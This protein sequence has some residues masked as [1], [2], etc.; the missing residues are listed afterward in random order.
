MDR[1][2]LCQDVRQ[3]ISVIKTN[4]CVFVVFK[5][6]LVL[7]CNTYHLSGNTERFVF[8]TEVI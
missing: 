3:M 6:K 2:L 8:I 7:K 1:Q 4:T 5:I